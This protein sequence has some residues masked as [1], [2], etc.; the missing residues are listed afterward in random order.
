MGGFIFE[1]EGNLPQKYKKG[2]SVPV[3]RI[4]KNGERKE[5]QSLKEAAADSNTCGSNI[6]AVL[7]GRRKTAGGYRWEPNL[8]NN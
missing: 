2:N 6:T 8:K 3:I 7:K 1:Y 4:D 5:Y